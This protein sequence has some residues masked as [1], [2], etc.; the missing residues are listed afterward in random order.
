MPNVNEVLEQ[1]YRLGLL[2]TSR[3]SDMDALLTEVAADEAARD[4]EWAAMSES[5][6]SCSQYL[7][8]RA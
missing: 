2:G 7:E 6:L 5:G 1:G 4:A 8:A 3:D